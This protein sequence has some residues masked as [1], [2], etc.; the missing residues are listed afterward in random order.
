MRDDVN[1]ELHSIACVRSD[2][3]SLIS[4]IARRSRPITAQSRPLVS[5][6]RC[7]VV[8]V[9]HGA[10]GNAAGHQDCGKEEAA[11]MFHESPDE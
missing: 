9:R 7:G 10:T 8:G 11:Y 4:I 1:A 2:R 3:R 6:V 5:F